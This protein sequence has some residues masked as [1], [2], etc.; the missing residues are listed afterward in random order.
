[1][2]K[3]KHYYEEIKA[4]IN[5]LDAE[6]NNLNILIQR[7]APYQA[8]GRMQTEQESDKISNKIQLSRVFDLVVPGNNKGLK[9][10]EE[11]VLSKV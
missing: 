3:I 1:M 10:L 4:L 8:H 6:F 9:T 7:V 11:F 2:K 5:K